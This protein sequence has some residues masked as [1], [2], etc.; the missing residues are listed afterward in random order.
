MY[1][2]SKVSSFSFRRAAQQMCH[3]CWEAFKYAEPT[4]FCKVLNFIQVY[5]SS[6]RSWLVG[7]SGQHMRLS[8]SVRWNCLFGDSNRKDERKKKKL[9]RLLPYSYGL[10]CI[11][12]CVS[13]FFEWIFACVSIVFGKRFAW[14]LLNN[15]YPHSLCVSYILCLGNGVETSY[16]NRYLWKWRC[17]A[18]AN[19]IQPY[20]LKPT[21]LK[22]LKFIESDDKKHRKSL[23][24]SVH[25][26]WIAFA[27]ANKFDVDYHAKFFAKDERKKSISP[28]LRGR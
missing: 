21:T 20:I 25:K 1:G 5:S 6:T 27:Y 7:I 15:V 11:V 9:I 14:H 13:T 8:P 12:F 22:W 26:Y 28:P 23:Y 4:N 17:M 24:A 2:I 19:R 18:C 10:Y 3:L 16:E